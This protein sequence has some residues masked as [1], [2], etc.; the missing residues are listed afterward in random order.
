MKNYLAIALFGVTLAAHAE[1]P[2][3]TEAD[4]VREI[5]SG[6]CG[7]LPLGRGW[8]RG[9]GWIH[10]PVPGEVSIRVVGEGGVTT[11]R[12]VPTAPEIRFD[13]YAGKPYYIIVKPRQ[14]KPKLEWKIPGH[15]WGP[16]PD[17]FMVEPT[18]AGVTPTR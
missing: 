7:A 6:A 17:G 16:I 12:L 1:L 2:A 15:E 3:F 5:A 10:Q 8:T 11:S 14:A 9:E 13:M 4:A 18:V